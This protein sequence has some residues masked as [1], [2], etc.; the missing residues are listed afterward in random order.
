M[1]QK[2]KESLSENTLLRDNLI[3]GFAYLQM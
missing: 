3:A 1:N 2:L